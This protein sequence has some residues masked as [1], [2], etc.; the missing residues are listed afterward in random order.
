MKVLLGYEPDEPHLIGLHAV[1]A[2]AEIVVARCEAEAQREIVDADAYLGNRWFLQALPAA[3]RLAWMQSGSSGMDL[4]LRGGERLREVTITS[5]RGVY[6]DEVADHAVALLLM[7]RRRLHIAR[8][9]QAAH[10]WLRDPLPALRGTRAMVLGFGGVGRAIAARL[11]SFGIE[12]EG[13]RRCPAGEPGVLGPDE[14]RP[15]LGRVDHLLVALPET[16]LTRGI[17]GH[18]ELSALPAGA[19]ILNV[20]RGS[21][22]DTDALISHLRAGDLAG[23]ALDVFEHEPLPATHP[24][25][26]EERVVITPH[27]ARSPELAPFRWEPLFEENLRRFVAGEPLL[28]VVEKESGY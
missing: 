13:V 28:N 1:A 16:E 27:V 7:L 9:N 24:L 19:V 12:V 6:D 11:E 21:S 26:S 14:W 3:R 22:I 23:A 8:D 10:R 4:V 2:G 17:V 18:A 5:A 15:R 25:W 20:G